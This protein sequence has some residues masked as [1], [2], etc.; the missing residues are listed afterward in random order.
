MMADSMDRER[1]RPATKAVRKVKA[2]SAAALTALMVMT[3]AC[4]QETAPKGGEISERTYA[5]SELEPAVVEAGNRFGLDLY[6]QMMKSDPESNIVMSPYSVAAALGMVGLGAQGSTRAELAQTLRA[7]RLTPEVW[8]KGQQVLRDLLEHAGPE[9]SLSVANSIW[10]RKGAGLKTDYIEQAKAVFAAEVKELDFSQESKASQTINDWVS[11]KTEGKIGGIIDGPLSPQAV[12]YVI[13]AL[14]FKGEWQNPF[15][16]GQTKPADF[17]VTP[18]R[19]QQVQMM[20]QQSLMS[21]A[22]DPS[23]QAVSLP[24]AGGRLAMTIV[25]PSE[26]TD[27]GRVAEQLAG[28]MAFWSRRPEAQ[29]VI[30]E[31][32]RFKLEGFYK[33]NDPLKSLGLKEAFEAGRAQFAGISAAPLHMD[34]VLHKTYLDVNEKGTEAAAVTAIGMAGSAPVQKEPVRMTVNRPFIVAI[35]STETGSLLFLGTVRKPG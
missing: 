20:K 29:R 35:Q 3:T 32:P 16:E 34:Q 22:E 24:Y 5:P 33:L 25:L 14:Y 23:Y 12:L 6:L 2:C 10:A 9:V 28:D 30:L 15:P 4:G 7:D 27:A 19:P 21:Y 18:E 8:S 17:F 26:H 11:R 31:L 13:N 1:N